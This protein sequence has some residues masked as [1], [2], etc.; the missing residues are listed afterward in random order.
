MAVGGD[1]TINEV[2][3]GFF[4]NEEPIPTDATLAVIP[5][6]TASDFSRALKL[7]LGPTLGARTIQDGPKRLIDVMKVRYTTCDQNRKLRYAINVASFGLGG[8][9]ADIVHRSSKAMG[10]FLTFARPP[11]CKPLFVF[12]EAR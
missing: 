11:L 9:V 5:H 12:Q 6:G 10:A 4:E 1:G 2:V 8:A 7:P 3:N